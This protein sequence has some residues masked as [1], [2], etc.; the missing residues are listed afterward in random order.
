MFDWKLVGDIAGAVL[1]MGGTVFMLIRTFKNLQAS[2]AGLKG[3][4][5]RC[6]NHEDRIKNLEICNAKIES[7][8]ASI[9]EKVDTVSDDLKSLI[10]L[11]L[12]E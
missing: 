6:I 2:R 4:P 5:T 1:V 7:K 3:N 11:H 10:K 9:D 8:L 12:K